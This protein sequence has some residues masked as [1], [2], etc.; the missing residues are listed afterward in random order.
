[1]FSEIP[2]LFDKNFA[3]GYLIPSIALLLGFQGLLYVFGIAY[4][5]G[6]LTV[7]NPVISS[8]VVV[9]LGWLV[10]IVLAATNRDIIRLLEGYGKW[11]PL[12]VFLSGQKAKFK[13]LTGRIKELEGKYPNRTE[14]EKE[15]LNDLSEEW[16]M[17]FPD[18][19]KWVLPTPFGNAIRAFE[20][21]PRV[22]Y[23]V[24]A[25]ALWPRLLTVIPAEY[26][27]YIDDAK[28]PM[29]FWM[30]LGISTFI[31]FLSS[32]GMRVYD[33]SR[34]IAINELLFWL[35]LVAEVLLMALCQYRAKRSAIGWGQTV[36]SAFD[37]YLPDLAAKIGLKVPETRQGRREMWKNYGIA[38]LHAR[39]DVLP[40][41]AKPQEEPE[42]TPQ[43]GI[44]TRIMKFLA[45][46]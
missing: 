27:A 7:T 8:A 13:Q 11:N 16:V 39:W 26:T 3:V 46:L 15:E 4:L 44:L 32:V 31:L 24:D 25:I 40:E 43:E 45:G 23:G 14:P 33:F 41:L 12:Q 10:G 36:K 17:N 29:D 34:Q 2:K 30:N 20:V 35:L 19:G 21:Y 38:V 28:A 6:Y 5:P 37:V 1:M 9:V 18:K 42:E 22:M